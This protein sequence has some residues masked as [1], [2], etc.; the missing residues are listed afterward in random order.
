MTSECPSSSNICAAV[1]LAAWCHPAELQ[2]TN[3]SLPL[4]DRT[5]HHHVTSATST[6]SQ[7]KKKKNFLSKETRGAQCYFI[8]QSLRYGYSYL[9]KISLLLNL[10][11]L[12]EYKVLDKSQISPST[13]VWE[14]I[15]AKWAAERRI[16]CVTETCCQQTTNNRAEGERNDGIAK[17]NTSSALQQ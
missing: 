9:W 6:S 2:P 13:A 10:T 14:V 3:D 5:W 16:V 11:L 1:V 8:S 17:L 15:R 4:P 12:S 7:K